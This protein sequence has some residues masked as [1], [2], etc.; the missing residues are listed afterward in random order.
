MEDSGSR[1]AHSS[2]HI[3]AAVATEIQS[4]PMKSWRMDRNVAT[5]A[6]TRSACSIWPAHQAAARHWPAYSSAPPAGGA[7]VGAGTICSISA[8]ADAATTVGGCADRNAATSATHAW[9]WV[10]N[11]RC[12]SMVSSSMRA[13]GRAPEMLKLPGRSESRMHVTMLLPSTTSCTFTLENRAKLNAVD[14]ES[15][16]T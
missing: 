4:S 1:R 15:S 11:R 12:H 13:L 7:I 14:F 6:S 16:K 9:Q 3:L 5:S 10:S 8:A 2:M